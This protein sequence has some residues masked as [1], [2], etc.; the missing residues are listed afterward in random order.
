MSSFHFNYA[1]TVRYADLDAQ[2]HM[3]NAKFITFMEQARFAY[4]QAVGLWQTAQGFEQFG[5]IVA[6][7]TCDYKRPV[8][9]DQVVDVAV[10]A[11][12]LGNKSMDLEYRLTVNGEE[13]AL[14][15]TV[16]VAYDF[17][18]QQSV[19]IPPEWRAKLTAFESL[20]A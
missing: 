13:V 19:P 6:S 11:A 12:R 3:N 5:Q 7:V 20:T 18:T 16:Q 2:G 15:R 4:A 14:G 8:R 10:R 17:K 9:L 1:I